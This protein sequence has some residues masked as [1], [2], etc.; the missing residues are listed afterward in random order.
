MNDKRRVGFEFTGLLI[1]AGSLVFVAM[2]MQQDR[3]I[4]LAQLN[5]AQLEL[6][7]S[8]FAAGFESEHYLTMYS[9]LWATNSW[10][11]EGLTDK[12]VAAAEL[13]AIMWWTYA[14]S[15]F[16]SYREGLVTDEAWQEAET[17]IRVMGVIPHFWAVY[18]TL[19]KTTPSRFT[20]TV[21]ELIDQSTSS[22][23]SLAPSH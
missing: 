22:E 6:F 7:N 11:R 23:R 17:E 15:V 13:E 3:K 20:R 19:W 4:A 1:L 2:Q 21:D 12:E 14:E 16:E 8:R 5:L 18:D 9:K 10:D